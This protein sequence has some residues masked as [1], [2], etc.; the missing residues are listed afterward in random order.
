MGKGGKPDAD[1]LRG[2]RQ[3]LKKPVPPCKPRPRRTPRSSKRWKMEAI[4]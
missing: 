2:F 4:Y 3:Q 1:T